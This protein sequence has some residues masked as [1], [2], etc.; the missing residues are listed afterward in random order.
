MIS[1]PNEWHNLA[2]K[3]EHAAV[4]AEH[5]KWL[6]SIDLPPAPKSAARILTYDK[7]TDQ[8]TWEGKPFKRTD[9]IPQ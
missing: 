9:P 2:A 4:I 1:D 5:K 7:K 3:P 8:A 6:P